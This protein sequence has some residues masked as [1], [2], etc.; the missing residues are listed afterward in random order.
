MPKKRYK[1]LDDYLEHKLVKPIAIEFQ[2]KDVIQVIIGSLILS[3]PISL[4]Q[5][6]WELGNSLP[7]ENIF[8]IMIL[9]I[10]LISVFTYYHYHHKRKHEEHAKHFLRRVLTTYLGALFIAALI[11][12]LIN[13][14]NWDLEFLVSFKKS[15]IVALSGSISAIITD[16]I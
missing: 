3:L 10:G 2:K 14:T 15:V 6:T 9:S 13:Q 7:M 11:L 4:T 12:S 1:K 8:F 16:T 5:E